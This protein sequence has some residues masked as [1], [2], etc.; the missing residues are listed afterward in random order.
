LGIP[1]VFA[2]V[3]RQAMDA[4]AVI[5]ESRPVAAPGRSTQSDLDATLCGGA[6]TAVPVRYTSA[7]LK[8]GDVPQ[9]DRRKG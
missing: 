4:N 7:F 3:Y 1:T 5:D 2:T 8:R 9:R 6:D